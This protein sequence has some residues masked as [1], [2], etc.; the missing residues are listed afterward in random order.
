MVG[1]PHQPVGPLVA[2][3][4]VV[5]LRQ[6]CKWNWRLVWYDFAPDFLQFYCRFQN[7][8]RDIATDYRLR[9]EDVLM[10][11]AKFNELLRELLHVVEA[12]AQLRNLKP[13]RLGL[14]YVRRITCVVHG[15]ARLVR[16][17]R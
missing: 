16:D 2:L 4:K 1:P 13:D 6:A 10:N 5:V 3:S 12:G 15:P 17:E 11:A 14:D 8:L 9:V 7:T